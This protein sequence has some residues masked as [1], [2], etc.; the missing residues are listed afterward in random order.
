MWHPKGRPEAITQGR[1]VAQGRHGMWHSKEKPD[2]VAQ[3]WDWR[4]WK[5][6][7]ACFYGTSQS[8]AAWAFGK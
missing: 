1:A 5:A 7:I 4:A 6:E 8:V 3:E 2:T